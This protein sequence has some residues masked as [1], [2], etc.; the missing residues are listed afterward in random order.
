MSIAP[1]G[2]A[3]PPSPGA[4]PGLVARGDAALARGDSISAIGYY[5]DAVNRAPRDTA[6]YAALGRAYL[7]LREPEHAREAFMA[8]LHNTRGSEELS[9]GLAQTYELLDDPG[10]ALLTLRELVATGAH[11]QALLDKLAQLAEATG[12]LSEALAARRALMSAAAADPGKAGEALRQAQIRVSALLLLL[13]PA[14][15]LSTAHCAERAGSAFLR[16]LSSCP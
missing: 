10:H 12:A 13:G 1:A 16:Q 6:G 4:V 7:T 14:D 9:L 11:S 2:H 8:G 3:L 15:R 5:R